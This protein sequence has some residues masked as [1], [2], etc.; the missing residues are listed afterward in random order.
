M[1]KT[2]A[3]I[4]C[5]VT[6]RLWFSIGK[7]FFHGRAHMII[8]LVPFSIYKAIIYE[9]NSNKIKINFYAEN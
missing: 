9:Q 2:K 3:L 5:A 7:I 4:R 1:A 8:I 6:Q